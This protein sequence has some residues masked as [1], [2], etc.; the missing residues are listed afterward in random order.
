VLRYSYS[1]FNAGTLTGGAFGRI[2]PM[3]NWHMSDNV[4]L[5]FA[6]GYGRLDRFDLKGNTQF[7]QTRI[8]FQ[9]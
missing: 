5:E 3:V 7:F 9:I 1:D 8:Q 6:Y 4:R 2:T